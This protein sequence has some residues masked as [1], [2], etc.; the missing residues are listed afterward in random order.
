[1]AINPS[2]HTQ[3]IESSHSGHFVK[4]FFFHKVALEPANQHKNWQS[5]GMSVFTDIYEIEVGFFFVAMAKN[6]KYSAFF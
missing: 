3:S 1:M 5:V 2:I 6:D 4:Q